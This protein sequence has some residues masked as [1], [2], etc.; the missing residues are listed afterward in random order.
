VLLV[1]AP[2]GA[3]KTTLALQLIT[4]L[5]TRYPLRAVV[6]NVET[7]PSVLLDKLLARLA[8]V[9]VD[10]LMNRQLLRSDRQQVD[11]AIEQYADVLA[12]LAFLPAPW[13]RSGGVPNWSLER[14]PRTGCTATRVREWPNWNVSK[15][16]LVG[17]VM[18][19]C[20][21]M[22]NTNRLRRATNSTGSTRPRRYHER[23][24]RR[25]GPFTTTGFRMGTALPRSVPA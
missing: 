13:P 20:D 12:R 1:G 10:A 24:G 22:A 8:Q 17:P 6:A 18:C 21:S 11:T 14:I 2:P 19:R 5:L 9:P 7:A 15:S 16:G 23:S 25:E 4:D 3:G